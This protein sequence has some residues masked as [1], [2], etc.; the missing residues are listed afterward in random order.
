MSS[1][2]RLDV[3]TIDSLCLRLA[4]GQPLLARLGGAL[5]PTEDAAAL[6]AMAARRT[7]ALLGSP[8]EP[9]LEAA[10]GSLLLRRDNNLD[11]CERLL[12]GMLARR[13]A[14]LGVLPL[15]PGEN[16]DWTQV[17]ERLEQ[18]FA[19]ETGRV[20]QALHAAFTAMPD[21]VRELLAAARYAAANLRHTD[22]ADCDLHLLETMEAL[23]TAAHEHR[24]HWPRPRFP[25][26]APERASGGRTGVKSRAFHPQAP[27]PAL[28]RTSANAKSWR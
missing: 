16:V 21:L 5:E 23:P 20:L 4:H 19:D 26:A 1:R 8:G 9:E 7:T 11:E 13:D 12:A 28:K 27:V 3:Q 15:A 6:Y 22:G 14:W 25:A 2:T 17:R 18:P 10:L 24:E